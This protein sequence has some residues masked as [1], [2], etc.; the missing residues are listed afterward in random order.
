MGIARFYVVEVIMHNGFLNGSE[1]LVKGNF[2][3]NNSTFNASSWLT[4]VNGVPFTSSIE[5]PG[6]SPARSANDP[7]SI[8]DT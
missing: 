1:F 8:R 7:S 3:Q 6:R 5:S 4:D 2:E